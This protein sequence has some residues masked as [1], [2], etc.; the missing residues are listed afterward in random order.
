MLANMMISPF[1]LSFTP[2]RLVSIHAGSADTVDD[3]NDFVS[4]A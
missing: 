3:I 1:S 2:E 4:F